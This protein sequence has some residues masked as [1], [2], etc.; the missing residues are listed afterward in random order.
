MIEDEKLCDYAVKWH[1]NKRGISDT[2]DLY[3]LLRK[4]HTRA[5]ILNITSAAIGVIGVILAVLGILPS[6]PNI[7][8]WAFC[9]ASTIAIFTA[10]LAPRFLQT[11]SFLTGKTP[12]EFPLPPDI[13]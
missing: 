8:G 4:F 11:R 3:D 6:I 7:L 10:I 5:R 12:Y 13:E 1:A 2:I 9:I